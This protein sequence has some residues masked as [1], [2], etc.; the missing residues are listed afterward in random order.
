MGT[1][2]EFIPHNPCI[3]NTDKILLLKRHFTDHYHKT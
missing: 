2:D 1:T 3:Q